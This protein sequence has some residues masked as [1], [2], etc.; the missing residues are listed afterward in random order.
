MKQ[1]TLLILSTCVALSFSSA[2]AMAKPQRQ[3]KGPPPEAFEIC[4]DKALGDEV[5]ITT[6]KGKEVAASC[7]YSPDDDS[8]LV[9]VPNNHK[10]RK[11]HSE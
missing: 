6:R 7:Q 10:A 8:V 9:A 5:T 3:Q 2:F 1:Q 11:V 4:K